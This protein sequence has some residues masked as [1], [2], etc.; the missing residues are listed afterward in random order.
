MILRNSNV[1]N[2]EDSAVLGSYDGRSGTNTRQCWWS[3]TLFMNVCPWLLLDVACL[4]TVR[5]GFWIKSL[6]SLP[7]CL[8][9]ILISLSLHLRHARLIDSVNI[10]C[11]VRLGWCSSWLPTLIRLW[12]AKYILIVEPVSVFLGRLLCLCM[13]WT[14]DDVLDV[15]SSGRWSLCRPISILLGVL[16]HHIYAV[17]PK[18][19]SWLPASVPFIW[20]SLLLLFP[21]MLRYPCLL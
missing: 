6:E 19:C 13:L 16:G 21:L 17:V 5:L 1:N 20:F 10:S 15:T 7:F 9:N 8:V 12:W 3:F 14:I 11:L 2:W 18:V 4:G